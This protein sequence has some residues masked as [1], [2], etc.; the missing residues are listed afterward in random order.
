MESLLKG[1]KFYPLVRNGKIVYASRVFSNKYIFV[2]GEGPQQVCYFDQIFW[3]C[4][5]TRT[6]SPDWIAN[7][8]TS[9]KMP[10]VTLNFDSFPNLRLENGQVKKKDGVV[11][12]MEYETDHYVILLLNDPALSSSS[13]QYNKSNNLI[14]ALTTFQCVIT[15]K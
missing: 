10:Q 12:G 11:V 15:R 14:K 5:Q 6:L 3:R 8:Y 4:I 13:Y 2:I 9:I 1:R 7:D